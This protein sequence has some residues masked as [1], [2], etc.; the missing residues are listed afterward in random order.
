[1]MRVIDVRGRDPKE[2]L[3]DPNFVYV[4]D[5]C[6]LWPASFFDNP[7]REG[8]TR[9]DAFDILRYQGMLVVHIK[10]VFRPLSFQET[11]DYHKGLL[12]YDRHRKSRITEELR[13][14]TLGCWHGAWEWG[15]PEIACHA[16]DLARIANGFTP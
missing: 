1:M 10:D 5:A 4:G 6:Y 16:V 2:L 15:Q 9:L 12:C 14:K 8:M 7:F 3:A 11:I 13:G